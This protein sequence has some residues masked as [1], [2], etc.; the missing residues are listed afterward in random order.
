MD[1]VIIILGIAFL[2]GAPVGKALAIC[3]IVEGVLIIF[4]NAVRTYRK[5]R[6]EEA[7][8]WNELFNKKNNE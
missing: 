3:A 7:K 6:E 4:T 2:V 1:I 8:A 5:N